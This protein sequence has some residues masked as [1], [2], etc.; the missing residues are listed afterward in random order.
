[1]PPDPS[2]QPAIVPSLAAVRRG[3][4]RAGRTDAA[5]VV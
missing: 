1:M 5:R 4:E 2:P 3:P